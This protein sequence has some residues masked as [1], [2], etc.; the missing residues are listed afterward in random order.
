MSTYYHIEI[1]LFGGRG[2]W[3]FDITDEHV[4]EIVDALLSGNRVLFGHHFVE[5]KNID[6]IAIITTSYS[7]E[8]ARGSSGPDDDAT[9]F[10]YLK[11]GALDVTNEFIRPGIHT[12]VPSRNMDSN[13]VFI[14]HGHD[15]EAYSELAKLVKIGD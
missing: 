13:K 14:V 10:E 5:S 11:T 6:T 9:L 1:G 3:Q 4:S 12:N 15:K 8:D 2:Y 7:R